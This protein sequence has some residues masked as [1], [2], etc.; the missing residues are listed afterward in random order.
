MGLTLAEDVI[1][2]IGSLRKW[3]A[4]KVSDHLAWAQEACVAYT[5]GDNSRLEVYAERE[6]SGDEFVEPTVQVVTEAGFPRFHRATLQI[7]NRSDM[8]FE[9]TLANLDQ[10]NDRQVALATLDT[11]ND[12]INLLERKN[13]AHITFYDQESS[14]VKKVIYSLSGSQ[15]TI[16][17]FLFPACKL[18][19][20]DLSNI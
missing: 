13:S 10:A 12:I 17:S 11:R 7:D 15:K 14:A 16:A 18:G 8:S 19:F 9:L 5:S 20:T 3:K 6:K 4:V 2:D 1:S